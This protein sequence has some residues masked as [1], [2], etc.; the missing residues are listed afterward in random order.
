[1]M[2][3]KRFIIVFSAVLAISFGEI[4]NR[5][6]YNIV[7][8]AVVNNGAF[9]TPLDHFLPTDGRRI[10]FVCYNGVQIFGLKNNFVNILS[11]LSIECRI[12]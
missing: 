9:V 4:I 6:D 10:T 5:N 2:M 11:E 1:M 3:N 7:R 12:L 8:D